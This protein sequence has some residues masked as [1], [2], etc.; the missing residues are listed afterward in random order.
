MKY[1]EVIKLIEADG[2]QYVRTTAGH[3]HYKHPTKPGL[4]TV[5]GGGKMNRDVPSGTLDH[6][7]RQAGLKR[8]KE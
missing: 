3:L 7:L 8:P 5:S 2:W 1:R 6:I 4:V